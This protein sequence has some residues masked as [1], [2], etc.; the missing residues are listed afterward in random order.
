MFP[1]LPEVLQYSTFTLLVRVAHTCNDMELVLQPL[2]VVYALY[3]SEI[4]SKAGLRQPAFG[5]C[6]CEV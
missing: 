2:A 1:A 6:I 3:A 5:S 4:S